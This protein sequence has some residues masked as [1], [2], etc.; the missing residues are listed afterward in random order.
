MSA[1]YDVASRKVDVLLEFYFTS[2]P[3]EITNHDYLISFNLLEELGSDA[4]DNPIGS[5]SANE[6]DIVLYNE[7]GIFSPTNIDSPYYGL[8]RKGML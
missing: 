8:M 4:E 3:V 6:L 5:V 1:L 2:N 7:K